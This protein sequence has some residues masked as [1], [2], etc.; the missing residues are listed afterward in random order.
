MRQIK[1]NKGDKV[2]SALVREKRTG[3]RE[4]TE[5]SSGNDREY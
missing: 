1:R 2:K 3:E 5:R 4:M